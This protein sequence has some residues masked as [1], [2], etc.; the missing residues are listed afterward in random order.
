M[1]LTGDHYVGRYD[2][3]AIE[4]IRNNWNKTLR[5][6]IDGKEVDTTSC[7]LPGRF[8]LTG[9]LEHNGVRHIVVA[10]SIPRRVLWTQETIEVDGDALPLTCQKPRGLLRAAL[11]NLVLSII[12][13]VLLAL[14]VVALVGVILTQWL[15]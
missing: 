11:G 14:V 8:T 4:L 15:R 5:L 1:A 2:G 6:L 7:L 3:H 9:S 12:G 13:V 10:K